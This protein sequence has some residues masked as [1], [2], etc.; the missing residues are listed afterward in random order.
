VRCETLFRSRIL[1]FET[2]VSWTQ[3]NHPIHFQ[4]VSTVVFKRFGA[5]HSSLSERRPYNRQ[6]TLTFPKTPL[7]KSSTTTG[8]L[9]HFLFAFKFRALIPPSPYPEPPPCPAGGHLQQSNTGQILV[10]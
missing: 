5:P 2:P 1:Q 6:H 4:S 3:V 9:S 10:K 7:F 8:P